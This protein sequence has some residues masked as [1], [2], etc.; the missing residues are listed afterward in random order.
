M[1][2]ETVH[3]ASVLD[4]Q[5]RF[6]PVFEPGT[7]HII[8]CDTVILAIGQAADFSFLTPEDGIEITRQGTIKIDPETLMSTAPGIFA[9]GDIAFGPRLI[10]SATADGRK[11]A[12][13]MDRYLR[14]DAWK[15]REYQVQITVLAHT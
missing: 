14:G 9:A 5:Q 10:I 2:L 6:N 1:G 12:E 15:P 13:Q 4:S 8:P 3:C 11:A 7:E